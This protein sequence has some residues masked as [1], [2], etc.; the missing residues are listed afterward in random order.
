MSLR[1]PFETPPEAGAAVEVAEGVLWLRLPLLRLWRARHHTCGDP[2]RGG[3][4]T[5]RVV[6]RLEAAGQ[7]LRLDPQ[8]LPTMYRCATVSRDELALLRR[9]TDVVRL[10][11]VQRIERD[12][13]VLAGGSVPFDAGRLVVHC[14]AVPS[15]SRGPE[16]SGRHHRRCDRRAS[17]ASP[18]AQRD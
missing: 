14:S 4:E 7:L 16:P 6:L 8:V 1:F 11:R 3:C 18:P 17:G 2:P 9:I 15:R 10:G 5:R 13:L 12:R